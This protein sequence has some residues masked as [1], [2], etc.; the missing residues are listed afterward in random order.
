MINLCLP[1][2]VIN[3]TQHSG[4]SY[5]HPNFCL[6]L[7]G[8]DSGVDFA[9]ALGNY[10]KCI[11][12]PWGSN[13]Y[14]FTATDAHGQPVKVHCADNTD[15]I[16]TVAM[17]HANFYYVKKPVIGKIYT[18][19]EALYEEGTY[20]KATG[21]H[22][23]YEVAEG[24]QYG[25]SYDS[26][27]GV[28]RMTNELKPENVC[29]ICDS[30]STVKST[31]GATF[32]HCAGVYTEDIY[33]EMKTGMN[34]YEYGDIKFTAYL[35][36]DDYL[37]GLFDSGSQPLTIKEIDCSTAAFIEKC[38][39]DFFQMKSDQEDPYGTVY[40]PRVCVNGPID[41]PVGQKTQYLYYRLDKDGTVSFG[42]YEGG[43]VDD[44]WLRENVQMCCSP[45]MIF[46]ADWAQ[47][48]YAPMAGS[49]GI[50]NASYYQAY[51]GRT[52]EGKFFSGVSKTR[53]AA[54]K[55]WE[56]FRENFGVT[57]MAFMDGGSVEGNPGSA[58][59]IYW[60]DG[61]MKEA[62]YT[63]RAVRD[64]LGF[65]KTIGE[66]EN[67]DHNEHIDIEQPSEPSAPVEPSTPSEPDGSFEND[68][69]VYLDKEFKRLK[70]EIADAHAE[71]ERLKAIIAKAKGDLD[72][73]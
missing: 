16:V 25:K 57:D 59:Q 44:T 32:K 43:W 65:Y 5:S 27:M 39:N 35:K 66:P 67:S 26:A 60:K 8:S 40:G 45:Q 48:K 36:P 9:F 63:G 31:G 70:K 54:K 68:I 7:A 23:H 64:I 42:D 33:M 73:A 19:G 12:G 55:L 29:Y 6:D 14:F 13:T 71:N 72:E 41:Q 58:Q 3:V 49:A 38:G 18:N 62:Q 46:C 10:W 52:K 24:L 47:P 61:S 4:G 17:T 53:V 30:F 2:K 69:I 50:L 1:M 34:T 21:N 56:I 37:F 51:F 20:G 22:I 11:S 28:Y 15:R